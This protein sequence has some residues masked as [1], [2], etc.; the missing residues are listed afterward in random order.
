MYRVSL[1]LKSSTPTPV[2]FRPVGR[3]SL[4]DGSHP[5]VPVPRYPGQVRPCDPK[6]SRGPVSVGTLGDGKEP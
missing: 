3:Q 4:T 6:E 5:P 1:L 2:P